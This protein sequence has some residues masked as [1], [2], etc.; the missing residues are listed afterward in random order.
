MTVFS[1]NG[2]DT[3]TRVLLYGL[4]KLEN[5]ILLSSFEVH[6]QLNLLFM[7]VSGVFHCTVH[8]DRVHRGL[9]LAE[10]ITIMDRV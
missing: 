4:H 7:Q 5:G 1:P 3:L 6:W 2:C 8:V 9:V 10:V